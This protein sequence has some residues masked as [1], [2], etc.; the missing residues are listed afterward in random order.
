MLFLLYPM[1]KYLRGN[2]MDFKD[3]LNDKMNLYAGVWGQS[4]F[5]EKTGYV[6]ISTR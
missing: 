6:V 2:V 5:Q 4:G 3:K 1:L